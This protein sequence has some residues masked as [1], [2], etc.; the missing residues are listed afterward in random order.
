[1]LRLDSAKLLRTA[2]LTTSAGGG[3]ALL[4]TSEH[5]SW[6][7]VRAVYG[8]GLE[9]QWA[10]AL[11]GSNPVA[12]AKMKNLIEFVKRFSKEKG[13]DKETLEQKVMLLSEEVGELAKAARLYTSVKT[14]KHSKKHD[15]GE[16][17]ADVLYVLID[18]CNKLNIDLDHAFEDKMTKIKKRM[19]S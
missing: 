18:I 10:Q 16:E 11:T 4:T 17:A 14:G 2:N 3:Q 12:S 8:A 5:F 1:M 13:F 7:R 19:K 6:R 9:N 15:L